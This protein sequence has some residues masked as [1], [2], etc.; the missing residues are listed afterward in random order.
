MQPLQPPYL[1]HNISLSK[2]F[3]LFRCQGCWCVRLDASCKPWMT[4]CQT[5][6][7]SC[8][9]TWVP[10]AAAKLVAMYQPMQVRPLTTLPARC[11]RASKTPF[12]YSADVFL[13]GVGKVNWCCNLLCYALKLQAVHVVRRDAGVLSGV[14]A[15]VLTCQ[16]PASCSC[17]C[18][19][20][21]VTCTLLS[22]NFSA[23]G[24]RLLR[25]GSLHGSVLG[26]EAVLPDGSVLDLL[27]QLRKD[28]TG[29]DLK[30]L[31]IGSEGSLGTPVA[32]LL[33]QTC[34][35]KGSN[36]LGCYFTVCSA[37]GRSG[38]CLCCHRLLAMQVR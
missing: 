36:L 21:Y 12:M 10:R 27:R 20:F 33:W 26:V 17:I 5:A 30:Q 35:C 18:G 37:P 4:T 2:T 22:D 15:D 6:V 19:P 28:N 13:G 7:T 34:P 1:G 11:R 9:L 38:R 16:H 29:Y 25:Y 32:I 8:H 24:L 3:L 31:F 23:G 14:Q